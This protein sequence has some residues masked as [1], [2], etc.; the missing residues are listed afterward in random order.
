[1][2]TPIPPKPTS[3]QVL[4]RLLELSSALTRPRALEESLK[5]TSDALLSAVPADYVTACLLDLHG[6]ALVSVARTSAGGD[7]TPGPFRRGEG[8]AGWAA[9]NAESAV[10]EDAPSD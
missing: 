3:S 1:M 7:V 9:Q 4:A 2:T 5:L 10:V 6:E 8:I